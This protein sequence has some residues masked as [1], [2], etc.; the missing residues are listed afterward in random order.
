MASCHSNERGGAGNAA[1]A[2]DLLP[3]TY[4]ST[5]VSDSDLSVAVLGPKLLLPMGCVKIGEKIVF[6]CLLCM[7][8]SQIDYPISRSPWEVIISGPVH[9]AG[10]PLRILTQ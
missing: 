1:V 6:T 8:K 5:F 10:R 4:T 3:Q 2:C 9:S 7:N